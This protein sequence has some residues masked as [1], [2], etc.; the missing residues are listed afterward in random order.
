MET[1][2]RRREQRAAVGE[3][4]YLYC[5]VRGPKPKIGR[6]PP[7]LPGASPVRL[8]E[9]E[10]RPSAGPGLWLVVCG[11]PPSRYDG[12]RLARAM[13]DLRWVS[14]CA[15]AHE[16][17]VDRIGRLGPTLPLKRFTI[18]RDDAHAVAHA[19][20]ERARLG[21]LFDRLAGRKEFGLRVELDEGRARASLV[22]R[23]ARAGEPGRGAAGLR[24]RQREWS[25]ARELSGRARGVAAKLYDTLAAKAEQ[26]RRR[27]EVGGVPEARLLLDALFLVAEK[28]SAGFAKAVDGATRRLAADGLDVSLTGP[29]SP[30]HF[31]EDEAA[32]RDLDGQAPS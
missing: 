6:L 24:Q 27:G 30:Y 10:A 8:L 22:R 14:S 16:E 28:R 25:A 1:G 12:L 23:I 32:P 17:L 31:I 2:Q 5:L 11:V 19:R 29:G 21:R 18:F 9:V 3:L 26:A 7:G 20:G 15:V 4:T 13:K